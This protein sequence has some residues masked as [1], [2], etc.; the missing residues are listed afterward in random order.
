VL[1]N[2]VKVKLEEGV[3]GACSSSATNT[4]MIIRIE[5][6]TREK[7]ICKYEIVQNDKL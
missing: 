2:I 1:R 5:T 6:D 4:S 7:T 3:K